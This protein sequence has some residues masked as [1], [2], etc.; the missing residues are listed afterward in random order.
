MK[1]TGDKDNTREAIKNAG[2]LLSDDDLG[3]VSGGCG[4][5]GSDNRE[6]EWNPIGSQHEWILGDN[7]RLICRYCGVYM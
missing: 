7:G 6:C 4:G 2:K 1:Q 5:D 3:K